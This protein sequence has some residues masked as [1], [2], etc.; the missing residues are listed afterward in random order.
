MSF[1]DFGN[2]GFGQ[3]ASGGGGGLGPI[4]D[5]PVTFKADFDAD[6]GVT[7][8]G[9]LVETWPSIGSI[10]A[11]SATLINNGGANRPTLVTAD[12]DF[13]GHNS[14]SFNGSNHLY[15]NGHALAEAAM[16]VGSK[17]CFF[18]LSVETYGAS[19]YIFRDDSGSCGL[20]T[21]AGGDGLQAFNNDG[22][23]DTTPNIAVPAASTPC[24]V[25]LL[26]TGGNLSLKVADGSYQTVASGNSG[27]FGSYLEVGHAAD[28]AGTKITGKIARMIF[29]DAVLTG[30]DLLDA[31]E[32]L[33]RTYGVAY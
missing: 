23:E 3:T 19:R 20:R 25:E 4:P 24:L 22:A 11:A 31:R 12:A 21:D 32:N 17:H 1:F 26:H 13:N 5:M 16:N 15:D 2:F 28:G 6:D 30:Q 18:V 10:A 8:T 33:G 14:V 29:H 7:V 27:A 9:A